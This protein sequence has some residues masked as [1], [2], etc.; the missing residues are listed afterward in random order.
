MIK[1][2]KTGLPVV[3]RGTKK[4]LGFLTRQDMFNNP[5]EIQ[6]S[7]LM[8]R[9]HPTVNLEADIK[10]AGKLLLEEDLHHIP[11]LDG[12]E[13]VGVVTAADFLPVIEKKNLK[14]PV[15]DLVREPC[16]AVHSS[17]PLNAALTIIRLS[18]AYSLPVID[19][20]GTLVGLITDRDIFN[21]TIMEETTVFTDFGLG[22]DEDSWSWQGLKNVMKL[23]FEEERLTLPD[24][25][26]E[27]VM[28]EAVTLFEKTSV[29]EAAKIMHAH[30]YG[31]LPLR[32]TDDKL[33]S[34]I[35]DRD[36][37]AALL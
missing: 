2:S 21:R 6:L 34:L 33:T 24:K 35:Y 12:G 15:H 17:T 9:D 32:G 18:K 4:L 14:T 1:T 37:I 22:D 19:N 10:K 3:K 20:S 16:V 8:N 23:Y 27:D 26:V 36:L 7:M 30:D 31:Q 5:T 11:V 29:S 25:N 28:V 13:L